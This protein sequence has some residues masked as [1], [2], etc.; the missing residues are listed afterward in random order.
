[1]LSVPQPK[2]DAGGS[3]HIALEYN[4]CGCVYELTFDDD[5]VATQFT[6][7][8][9]GS[10]MPEDEFGQ[11]CDVDNISN[12]DNIARIGKTILIGEDT[13]NH[14][15]D[16]MWAWDPETGELRRV[17]TTPYGSELTGVGLATELTG[18]YAYL[19]ATIQHPYG[20]SDIDK[21][22]L[23]E[24]TGEQGWAI[25]WPI[26]KSDVESV[27]FKT[28]DQPKNEIEKSKPVFAS[29]STEATDAT[30]TVEQRIQA[31]KDNVSA[32]AAEAAEKAKEE[33]ES[34]A[35][36]PSA[37]STPQTSAASLVPVTVA[38]AIGVAGM[39]W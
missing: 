37:P 35:E 13:D 16:F 34:Q 32:L 9:C 5:F 28:V 29:L 3:Q 22:D 23:S 10:P 38:A 14:Q 17:G 6:G 21:L 19:T 8:L 36:A 20:E 11:T 2:Y 33:A 30:S 7:V 25:A 24:S 18:D 1:M 12:P 31:A 15:N 4:K 27:N 39:V 26:L